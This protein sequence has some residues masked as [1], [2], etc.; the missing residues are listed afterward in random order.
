MISGSE[1]YV[2]YTRI[3]IKVVMKFVG[4]KKCS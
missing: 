2:Q 4:V 1:H 3:Y